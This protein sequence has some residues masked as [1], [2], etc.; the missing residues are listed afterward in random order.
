MI[1]PVRC[2]VEMG[3]WSV[4]PFVLL[5]CGNIEEVSTGSYLK[6][7]IGVVKLDL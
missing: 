4:Y 2:G 7:L 5:Q 6:L 3:L 1:E